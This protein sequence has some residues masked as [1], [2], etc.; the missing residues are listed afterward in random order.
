MVVV[1]VGKLVETWLQLVQE[2]P[3]AG[4][5]DTIETRGRRKGGKFLSQ[6]ND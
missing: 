3:V 4:S 5:V 1:V 2:C 6:M